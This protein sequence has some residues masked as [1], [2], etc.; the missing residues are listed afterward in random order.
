MGLGAFIRL[1]A[2]I[3]RRLTGFQGPELMTCGPYRPI[4]L[5]T[6][7][8]RIAEVHP[9][10]LLSAQ[11][12]PSLKVDV[13]LSG[14]LDPSLVASLRVVLSDAAD[15]KIVLK[16]QDAPVVA[17]AT[18]N[19]GVVT[20]DL[21]GV[22]EPWWPVGYG[23]QP[24]YTVSVVLLSPSGHTLDAT[25][26]R[27]GFRR[28]ALVQEPLAEPDQYGTGTTFLFKVNGVRMFMGGTLRVL[29]LTA[30]FADLMCS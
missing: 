29:L 8:A 26:T 24:L 17:G 30:A 18:T 19:A 15:D 13:T 20:W 28:V 23:A 3:I 5:K 11:N 25:T 2:S 12:S 22:V 21:A 6:Y 10:A 9:H 1:S 7:T 16:S 14:T 4:T 27:V